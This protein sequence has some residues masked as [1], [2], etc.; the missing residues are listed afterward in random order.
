MPIQ[1][2]AKLLL[3]DQM[4]EF[5]EAPFGS[6][7][8][9]WDC[10]GGLSESM[11]IGYQAFRLIITA[12]DNL[13]HKVDLNRMTALYLSFIVSR[14]CDLKTGARV[15][16]YRNKA[17]ITCTSVANAITMG[18]DLTPVEIQALTGWYLSRQEMVERFEGFTSEWW[19]IS[20]SI[21]WLYVANKNAP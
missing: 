17:S 14:W 20:E 12:C 6:G 9:R 5:W 4:K 3:S 15:F 1:N 21:C 10:K 16:D 19:V 2:L 13:Y 11:L 8:G 7:R 18:I